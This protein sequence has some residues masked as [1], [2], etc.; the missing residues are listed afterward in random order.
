MG[1]LRALLC[2][3]PLSLL[4]LLSAAWLLVHFIDRVPLRRVGLGDVADGVGGAEGLGSTFLRRLASSDWSAF[5]DHRFHHHAFNGSTDEQFF[6]GVYYKLVAPSSDDILVVIP[7]I[8]LSRHNASASEAFLSVV[9]NARVN[10]YRFPVSEF[11]VL[12]G[13]APGSRSGT[14][15]FR[16][17]IGRSE[18]SEQGV[19]IDV[20]PDAD[21][22]A[23]DSV[24]ADITFDGMTPWTTRL[25]HPST[26]GVLGWLS[27]L[28]CYHHV[29]SLHHRLK[30][31]IRFEEAAANGAQR[32]ATA[33]SADSSFSPPH[34]SP[35]LSPGTLHL[36]GG[37]G[38]MEKDWGSSFPD[39][40]I[41][42]QSN[43][44]EPQQ[45]EESTEQAAAS[46]S[47]EPQ[48]AAPAQ[49]SPSQKRNSAAENP[50]SLFLSI[51]R[52]PMPPFAAWVTGMLGWS[53]PAAQAEMEAAAAA[54]QAAALGIDSVDTDE[55]LDATGAVAVPPTSPSAFGFVVGF[56]LREEV[57]IFASYQFDSLHRFDLSFAP[58]SPPSATALDEASAGQRQS[59]GAADDEQ[60][61]GKE[62]VRLA[63]VDAARTRML[64]VE[65]HKPVQGAV[66]LEIAAM[67]Q[68][69]EAARAAGASNTSSSASAP[70]R[71][72][73]VAGLYGPRGGRMDKYV[74]EAL[75][76]GHMSV[77]F[78]ALKHRNE[79][80]GM[81]EELRAKGAVDALPARS[82]AA[83]AAGRDEAP[84]RAGAWTACEELIGG[85]P[86]CS[87]LLYSSLARPSAMEVQGDVDWLVREARHV[88][89]RVLR[90]WF[91]RW[92]IQPRHAAALSAA[93]L[94]AV[95]GGIMW[96]WMNRA[97]AAKSTRP[98][99]VEAKPLT[100]G[101]LHRRTNPRL[102]D[103]SQ[104]N[105]SSN[106]V[107]GHANGHSNGHAS[108]NGHSNGANGH[109][110]HTRMAAPGEL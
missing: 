97:Q 21:D 82:L 107:N 1:L 39:A 16:M 37:V 48:Q 58:S 24:Y 90:Q 29:L 52:V 68:R 55:L 103:G 80:V 11:A 71:T 93:I 75:L 105:G 108:S 47:A 62:V 100:L 41:W 64:E 69:D 56:L 7:G 49:A 63:F 20:T 67:Q 106:G 99:V 4:C 9:H 5:H 8:F 18:F 14:G 12:D 26:M 30:G 46:D 3:V 36:D 22:D 70:V 86:M 65:L 44:F 57:H 25:L 32:P 43:H 73:V 6:E 92:I 95:L 79:V 88:D 96:S 76:G 60:R 94:S 54:A 27:G 33:D 72:P 87:S 35:D 40:W 91:L 53:S 23:R 102:S 101:A 59:H 84:L 10:Y 109:T 98:S 89:E 13:E 34:V 51:A 31:F 104:V 15:A 45:M 50:T 61:Q 42:A 110:C 77:R 19:H 78:H 28:E 85:E 2:G 74:K 66:A 83:R 38:Y 81:G 17:R